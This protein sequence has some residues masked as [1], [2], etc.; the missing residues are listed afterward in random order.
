M[1][2]HLALHCIR[3]RNHFNLKNNCLNPVSGF[4]HVNREFA[5]FYGRHCNFVTVLYVFLA[6]PEL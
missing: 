3:S 2:G 1:N 4:T 5:L 6:H